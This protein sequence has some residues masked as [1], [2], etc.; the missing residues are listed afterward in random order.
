MIA[1]ER[2]YQDSMDQLVCDWIHHLDIIYRVWVET[3]DV[4]NFSGIKKNT[5]PYLY[6]FKLQMALS[7]CFLQ[8]QSHQHGS[9]F[10]K[11]LNKI[12][13]RSSSSSDLSF[14]VLA[15]EKVSQN[16]TLH[17]Q[18]IEISPHSQSTASHM[19]KIAWWGKRNPDW[20]IPCVRKLLP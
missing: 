8:G 13:L 9:F 3:Y 15:N 17:L 19:R 2:S 12:F 16:S 7:F 18:L 20:K 10:L 6:L 4:I 14:N 11:L 1:D 5:V